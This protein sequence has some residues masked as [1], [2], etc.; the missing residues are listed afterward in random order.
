M[1]ARTRTHVVLPKNL[2]DEIDE[3]VGPRHRSEWLA[4]VASEHLKR[5]RL[6]LLAGK[7]AGSIPEG[8]VP[9]WD[10]LESIVEWVR[11]Q[12]TSDD[13]WAGADRR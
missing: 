5:E 9:E 11:K 12:R 10:T 13:P 8:E 3:L 2:V 1:E 4:E 7:A 6:K